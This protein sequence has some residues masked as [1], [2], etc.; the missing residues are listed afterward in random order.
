MPWQEVSHMSQRQEFVML[1]QAE[2]CNRRALCRHFGISPKT[3]YKWLQRAASDPHTGFADHSHRPHRSP[4]RTVSAVEHV[5]V[6]LRLEHPAWGARKLRRRLCD[7]GH[8]SLP[9]PSTVHAML[10]RHGLIDL[11]TASQHRAWQRFEHPHPNALW[12]MDFKGGFETQTARCHPLTVLDDHARFCVRLSAC[13]NQQGTTVAHELTAA[14]RRYG[15]PERMGMD[16]GSPWGDAADS[17]YTPLTVWLL[18]LDIH[19]THSR[20]YHPQTLGKDERFHRTLKAEVLRGRHFRDL[21]HVQ[22]RFD[23][24]RHCYNCERPHQALGFETP[25]KRYRPSPR[26][27]PE[28]LPSIEYAPDDQ[29]RR[30]QDKGVFSFH[31]H[32]LKISQAFRGYPI[33]LRPTTTDGC[34]DLH[35]CRR[36]IGA[37]DLRLLE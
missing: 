16:N 24:W 21:A 23:P 25:I 18:R 19:V 3:G 29:I 33:A 17:P 2:G 11:K 5:L 15:L 7:L 35:F 27:F 1:A 4:R 36:R 34:F 9:A 14:F 22:R 28:T 12:Q 37:I 20:P 13:A 10:A 8:V 32:R 31:G 30:V 6:A 26:S